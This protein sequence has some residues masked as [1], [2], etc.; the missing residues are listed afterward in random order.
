MKTK[1][2][3]VDDNVDIL[4]ALTFILEDVSYGVIP[5]KTGGVVFTVPKD[6]L[7]DLIIIDVFLVDENGIDI[8]SQLKKT[9]D[10]NHIPVIVISSNSQFKDEALNAGADVFLSKPFET[11]IFLDTIEKVLRKKI[12]SK[13]SS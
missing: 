3:L 13:I 10:R 9:L 8:V 5:S 7:P 12:F 11:E 6:Q 4:E 1:I 2:L